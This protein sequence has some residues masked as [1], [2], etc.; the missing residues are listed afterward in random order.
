MI[1]SIQPIHQ[2]NYLLNADQIEIIYGMHTL[3]R[4]LGYHLNLILYH[5][6]VE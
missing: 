6:T 4:F 1:Q 5:N 3:I 2:P